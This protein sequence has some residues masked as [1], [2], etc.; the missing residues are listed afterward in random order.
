MI[1][2]NLF[3]AQLKFGNPN[4]IN[5]PTKDHITE[6]LIL[7]VQGHVMMKGKVGKHYAIFIKLILKPKSK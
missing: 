1:R 2:V 7:L 6:M 5:I 3:L 4:K